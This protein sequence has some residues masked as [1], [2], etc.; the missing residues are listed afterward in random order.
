MSMDKA[1]ASGKEHRKKYRGTKAFDCSCRNHGTCDYCKSNRLY[2][3]L[4]KMQE[5]IDKM[6]QEQYNKYINK[7]EKEV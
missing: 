1:I 4:K 2:K 3:N 6:L 5:P 7:R